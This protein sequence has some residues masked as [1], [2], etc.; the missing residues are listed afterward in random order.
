MNKGKI[1]FSQ[2]MDFI[3]HHEFRRCVERYQGNYKARS[4]SCM[5]QFLCMAF[6]QLTG[7]ESLRDI[8]VCLQAMR[9]KLYHMGIRGN[10]SKSTLA[11]ANEKRPWQIYADFAQALICIARP[12]YQEDEFKVDLDSAAYALD[13]TVMDLCLSLFPW[14]KA[15]NQRPDRGSVKMH[16]LLDLRGNIPAFIKVTN[17]GVS[18]VLILDDITPEP[19]S[20]YVMDRGYIDHKRLHLFTQLSAYFVIRAQATLSYRRL[21]SHPV[22]KSTGLKSDQTVLFKRFDSHKRYPDKL[23]RIHFLDPENNNDLVFLTNDFLLPA[24]SVCKLYKSRWQIELFFKWIKQH[25][26]IKAFYGRSFNAVKTQ[27]WMGVATYVLVAIIKKKLKLDMDLYRILQILGITI[28]EK[29]ELFQI[30]TTNH[31]KSS[32]SKN[33]NQLLLFEL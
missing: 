23:R 19:G 13:S 10:I 24:L 32:S 3:P 6:A 25:L 31:Y 8:E 22:D 4:F 11:D 28:F 14:S 20:F 27:I 17:A 16:T 9:S 33:D 30:L 12:L 5:D 21:Y 29:D 26:K 18:D 15:I 2:I 7:R 1:I